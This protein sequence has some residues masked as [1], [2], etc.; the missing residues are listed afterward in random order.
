M[1][2]KL[3]D[4]CIVSD[5]KSIL[6]NKGYSY[7]DKGSYNLNIIGVRNKERNVTNKFDDILVVEYVSEWGTKCKKC[8]AIT[9]DPGIYYMKNLMNK[10]GTA[11]L[12]PNQYKSTFKL[13]LHQGKY[14]ALVQ[15][16]TVKVYRDKNKNA[17]YDY[18]SGTVDEGI[19]GINIH[20]AGKESKQ[21]D[22]WSAGCQVFANEYDFNE[23]IALCEMQV[24]HNMGNSFTY[25][26]LNENDLGI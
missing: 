2:N 22:K 18:N 17:V 26:L 14:K 24:S 15:N 21:V 10:K 12:V 3:Y 1:N 5:F 6:K 25:T 4:K 13:G 23:F 7:F 8:Y 11:I 20:K 16:K 9:T 19:F